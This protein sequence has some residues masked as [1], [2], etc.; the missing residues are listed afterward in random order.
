[1]QQVELCTEVVQAK[2][3]WCVGIV[4][5]KMGQHGCNYCY[6]SGYWL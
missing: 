4:C 2:Q 6:S 3:W 5:C 1:M